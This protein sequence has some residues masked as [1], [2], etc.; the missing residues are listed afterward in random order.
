[1]S[2]DIWSANQQFQ[3]VWEWAAE[4]INVGTQKDFILPLSQFCQSSNGMWPI[5]CLENFS[6]KREEMKASLS[7]SEIQYVTR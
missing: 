7:D 4:S 1:M 6:I 2:A 3:S 5:S